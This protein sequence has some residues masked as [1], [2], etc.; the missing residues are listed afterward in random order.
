MKKAKEGR[1][2]KLHRRDWPGFLNRMIP[3]SVWQSFAREVPSGSD[4]RIRWSPKYVVLCWVA[5]SWSIQRQLTGRFREG[6]ELVARLFFHRRRPGDSYQGLTRATRRLG[7]EALH[8]F[9]CCLR[10]T[11]PKRLG[12][13]WFWYGWVV[14]AVDG[15]RIDAPRTGR[16]EKALGRAGRDK[17]HPQWWLTWMIHLPTRVIWDWRQGPGTSSERAHLRSMIRSLPL[18]TLLVADT[19]FGGFDLLSELSDA[20][21]AF[22]VRC[23]ANLTLLVDRT[24]QQ[25][26]RAGEHR[27][28][29]LWPQNRR[30]NKPL[31]LRLI[32]LKRKGKRVYLLTN[33]LEPERLSR[34]MAS[35]LYQARWGIEVQYRGLKQTLDHHKVLAKS[36]EP[37]A[38]ELAGYVLGM[39][40]L[41]LHGALVQGTRVVQASVAGLLRAIQWAIEAVRCGRSTV[42][43]LDRLLGAVTDDYVRRWSKRARDWPHKKTEH[44][45]GPP[46]LRR[47]TT[48]EKTRINAL[49]CKQTTVLG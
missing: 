49:L 12:A 8:R 45:A 21:V 15:S 29:Y 18:A 27:Y 4:P 19:G 2:L 16:N 22:L 33:V 23:G 10:Q 42:G 26:E 25:I 3:A 30:R 9:V 13:L 44:P 34:A 36:P 32:V 40:L 7:P 1:L 11:F 20:N 17:T 41:M 35:E 39:T 47:P 24:R 5:M 31:R 43:L 37:G 38:M 6:C 48:Y 46:R 28:V 14:L